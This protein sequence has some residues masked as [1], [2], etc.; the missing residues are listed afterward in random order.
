MHHSIAAYF[1]LA[2][3]GSFAVPQASGAAD[4]SISVTLQNQAIEL[5][6]TTSF[7]EGVREAK[8]PVGSSGPFT[9]VELSLGADVAQQDLRCQILDDRNVPIILLRGENNDTTFADGDGG[10]WDFQDGALL[11]STIICDPEFEKREQDLEIRVTLS[12]G[13][14]ATQTVFEQAGLELEQKAPV[15]SSGPFNT[16]NLDVGV[17]VENQALRCQI[18][19]THGNIIQLLRG[20]NEDETF[21]DGGNGAWDFLE[22]ASSEVANIICDPNFVL[23]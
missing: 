7:S 15:G 21:G 13:N 4:N 2:A 5:G 19:D 22:P 1:L 23:A 8:G 18:I 14:L 11:V 3:T 10:V 9:T 20:D 12:D 6:S 17:D 16:V